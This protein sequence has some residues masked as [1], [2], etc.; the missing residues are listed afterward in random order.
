[1]VKTGRKRYV[2]HL[3]I[4]V[5]FQHK[6]PC[7]GLRRGWPDVACNEVKRKIV[8]G[9]HTTGHNEFVTVACRDQNL[10]GTQMYVRKIAVKGGRKSPVDCR[11][12]ATQQAGFG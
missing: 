4:S 6:E 11:F 9:H 2:E 3:S 1:M 10:L 12:Q 7:H 5:P 8:P